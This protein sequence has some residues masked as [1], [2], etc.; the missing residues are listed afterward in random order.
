MYIIGTMKNK[1]VSGSRIVSGSIVKGSKVVVKTVYNKD[2]VVTGLK[3][4]AMG[5]YVGFCLFV[6]AYGLDSTM[7]QNSLLRNQLKAYN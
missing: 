5:L 3:Y 1:V 7:K 4:T 6:L 2:N